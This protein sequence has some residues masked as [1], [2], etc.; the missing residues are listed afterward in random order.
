MSQ[1]ERIPDWE[2]RIQTLRAGQAPLLT[3]VRC[4]ESL[5]STMDVARELL[6]ALATHDRALVLTKHQQQGRGRQGRRWEQPRS[7]FYGTFVFAAPPALAGIAGFSLVTGIAVARTLRTMGATVQLKWPN[8]VLTPDG[9]KLCG[10]LI[11]LVT[12]QQ[13]NWLLTGIGINLAGEPNVNTTTSSIA[14]LTGKEIDPC[15]VATALTPILLDLWNVYAVQGFAAFRSEWISHAYGI[16]RSITIDS[17]TD[18]TTG[19]FRGVSDRGGLLLER[20][21]ELSE[22]ISGHILAI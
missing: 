2:E 19:V 7:G 9:A 22:F 4:Y 11:D 13:T 10:I 12:E 15:E 20:G 18:R 5:G 1:L 14:T 6:P 21:S 8:D 3:H 17:G 16:G